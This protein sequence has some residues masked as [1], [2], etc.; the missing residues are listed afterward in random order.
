MVYIFS[1]VDSKKLTVLLKQ[2]WL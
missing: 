1:T 2:V